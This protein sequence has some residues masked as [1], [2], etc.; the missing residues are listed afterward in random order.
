MHVAHAADHFVERSKSPSLN[1]LRR[2]TKMHA[3][4]GRLIHKLEVR[5]FPQHFS[6]NH[7]NGMLMI[8][9]LPLLRQDEIHERE[10]M[11]ARSR[12][13]AASHAASAIRYMGRQ[14]RAAETQSCCAGS[15]G[16]ES[17][18]VRARGRLRR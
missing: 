13:K 8:A 3:S 12:L 9:G 6:S 11:R 14:A 2:G 16:E 10:E 5:R 17:E 18:A 7:S 4:V 1:A 15:Y